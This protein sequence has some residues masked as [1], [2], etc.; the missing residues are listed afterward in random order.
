MAGFISYVI[1]VTA[2]PTYWIALTHKVYERVDSPFYNV[3]LKF[4]TVMLKEKN[5]SL[6][7]VPQQCLHYIH[8][9]MIT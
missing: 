4:L 9:M 1:K 3:V 5:I 7:E 2:V 8:M 6:N